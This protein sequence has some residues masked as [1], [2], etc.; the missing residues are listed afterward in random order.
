MTRTGKLL[1]GVVTMIFPSPSWAADFNVMHL[2]A[3]T[4]DDRMVIAAEPGSDFKDCDNGC[5][6]MVLLPRGNFVMG[7]REDDSDLDASEHPP[8]EV[9]LAKSFAVSRFEVTFED[10]DAC[11]AAGACEGVADSWGRG[12]MPVINVSWRE[13]KQYVIWLSRS[14]GKEYRLLSEAEWEYAARAGTTTRYS[15]GPDAGKGNANCDGC[16]SRWDRQQTAPVGSFKSNAFGLYDMHGNVWEWVE[17]VWHS[18]YRGAPADGSPWLEGGDPSFRVIRGGSW[19]N[20]TNL[21]EAAVR[22]ERNVNVAFDT[23]GFRVAR[24]LNH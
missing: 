3:P 8:H 15:W 21:I 17:D 2:G 19:R 11:V 6:T 23:L 13:A 14:T 22:V 12:K 7:S 24:S 10:W 5:P 9:T 1:V 18:N 20:E 16:G 4:T